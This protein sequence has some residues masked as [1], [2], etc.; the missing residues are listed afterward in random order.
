MQKN[1]SPGAESQSH[2]APQPSPAGSDSDPLEAL[3]G[4]L[5]PP[6][7]NVPINDP[8]PVT[9]KGRGAFRP[10]AS[11]MDAR[12]TSSYD[13]TI[14]VQPDSEDENERDD[15]EMALE[16][17][18]DRELWK[19][20]GAQRLREAGFGEEAIKNW[21][22][23]GREKGVEDVKW[24]SKGEAREWDRGKVVETVGDKKGEISLEA[25]WKRKKG[26]FM[27]DFKKALG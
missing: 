20:K 27:A 7:K 9:S 22:D 4:P 21:K 24:S 3:V 18:R 11:A 25:A 12:F 2:R 8:P 10:S 26:G 1:R 19:R 16:A 5:P 17:H 13:P 14:D 6:P 15:W 23:S